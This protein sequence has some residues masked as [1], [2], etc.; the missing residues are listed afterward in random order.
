[1]NLASIKSTLA[2]LSQVSM[3]GSLGVGA[4]PTIPNFAVA[5][6]GNPIGAAQSNTFGINGFVAKTTGRILMLGL[7]TVDASAAADEVLFQPTIDG[8]VVPTSGGAQVSVSGADLN[9][10]A[11]GAIMWIQ[12]VA[13]NGVGHAYA[14]LATNATN[15][16]TVATDAG[17]ATIV[18]YELP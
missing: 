7:M 18:L 14:I 16:H 12:S 5:T 2:K 9:H 13:V 11:P 10:V 4:G 6:N 15:G 1:M 17:F 8:N 3:L